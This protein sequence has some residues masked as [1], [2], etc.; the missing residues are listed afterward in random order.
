MMRVAITGGAGQLGSDLVCELS[1]EFEIV[2]VDI[3][4]FDITNLD[5]TIQYLRRVKPTVVIHC[6]AFTDV[7]ACEI[8]VDKA[9]LV[10]GIGAR[11]VAIAARKVDARIVY[12][13]TDYV[14]DGE[15]VGPYREYDCPNPKTVYGATKLMGERFVTQQTHA[16]FILRIAWLYGRTGHNF[17][18]TISRSAKTRD[19]LRVVNDQHGT[20]TWAVDV[21]RQVQRLLQT[22]AYGTYHATS[23]GSCTW[24][25]FA[26]AL[27][28]EAGIDVPIVPVT[29]AEFPRPA[30]R[31]KNSVL[32]NFLLRIQGMDIMPTWQDALKEFMTAIDSHQ[33]SA[34]DGHW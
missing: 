25:E 33:W 3:P 6:A 14:F 29:T 2:S 15:K 11:N 30:P 9:Y 12:I 10:N 34:D 24:F 19:E 26:T 1:E 16:H 28:E 5:A 22:E 7:D 27:L 18:K 21:A 17:V 23:Q 8:E 31:P 13:S 20:P 32:D 4:D